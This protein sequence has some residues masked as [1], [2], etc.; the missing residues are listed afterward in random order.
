MFVLANE[1]TCIELT[2]NASLRTDRRLFDLHQFSSTKME[3]KLGTSGE[4]TGT[5]ILLDVF[6]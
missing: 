4:K 5:V 3:K 6:K 1:K 2:W